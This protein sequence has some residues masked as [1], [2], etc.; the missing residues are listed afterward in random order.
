QQLPALTPPAVLGLD[1]EPPQ[2]AQPRGGQAELGAADL[3]AGGELDPKLPAQAA[4]P[5]LGSGWGAGP[6]G[7]EVEPTVLAHETPGQQGLVGVG[8]GVAGQA[9]EPHRQVGGEPEGEDRVGAADASQQR[10]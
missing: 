5:V 1:L 6:G 8:T 2:Q 9:L 4:G 3:A 10:P 7:P